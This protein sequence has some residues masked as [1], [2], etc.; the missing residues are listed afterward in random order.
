M[1]LAAD[2]YARAPAACE[3]LPR[4]SFTVSIWL[5]NSLM[6]PSGT[7]SQSDVGACGRVPTTTCQFA[8]RPASVVLRPAQ[9][10]FPLPTAAAEVEPVPA[11]VADAPPV[12]TAAALDA[13]GVALL[14]AGSS[15]PQATSTQQKTARTASG[16][17]GERISQP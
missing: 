11:D 8:L 5:P 16:R 3:F 1:S 17:R 2:M 7:S 10:R 6:L 4:A 15:S 9:S 14:A 12:V 13:A